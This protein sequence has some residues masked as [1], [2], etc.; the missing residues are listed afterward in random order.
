MHLHAYKKLLLSKRKNILLTVPS[1]PLQKRTL[2][3]HI[4]NSDLVN[5]Q[6]TG[7]FV[8]ESNFIPLK[9]LIIIGIGKECIF[10]SLVICNIALW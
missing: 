4:Y 6:K 8:V 10:Y 9:N 2:F 7:P 1:L 3:N 5:F